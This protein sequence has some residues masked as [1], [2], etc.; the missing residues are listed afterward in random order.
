MRYA[1]L[2]LAAL[3]LAGC[4][5]DD[6]DRRDYELRYLSADAAATALQ[7]PDNHVRQDLRVTYAP[8]SPVI[9]LH[10]QP[11]VLDHA[12]ELLRHIDRVQMVR[13]RFQLIEADGFT[14]SDSSIADVEA[15][16]REMFRF[17]GYRLAAQS[18][19][20]G[21]APGHI[22]QQVVLPDGTPVTISADLARIVSDEEGAAV[23]LGINVS[24]P[25]GSI[26]STSLTVPG[27]RTAVVG[28]AQASSASGTLILVV[29]PE[30][31]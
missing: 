13:L 3:P 12:M 11:E 14:D 22:R 29:R 23:S 28:S 5:Q 2:I 31:D 25:A 19:V 7:Q 21:E 17:R 26:L 20:Q 9:T 4:D 24:L 27:G 18:V 8:G 16:L 6:G 1:F 10:G 15:A 30:I